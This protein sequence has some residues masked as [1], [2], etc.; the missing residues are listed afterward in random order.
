MGVE[1]DLGV[2]CGQGGSCVLIQIADSGIGYA[3]QNLLYRPVH[4]SLLEKN[5]D[6]ESV[7]S[8]REASDLSCARPLSI[9][10]PVLHNICSVGLGWGG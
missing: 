2:H 4:A 8:R 7:E 3:L 6:A 9:C 5:D 10:S 1:S